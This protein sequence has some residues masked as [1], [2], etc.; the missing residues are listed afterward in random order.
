MKRI[1]KHC[2]T[3]FEAKTKFIVVCPACH[4]KIKRSPTIGERSCKECGRKF[5]GGPRAW[6][7]PE[8]RLDRRRERERNHRKNG[9]A[10][11]IGSTDLCERCGAAYTVNSGLQ[12]YCP[13]CAQVAVYESI[14]EE[15]LEYQAEYRAK[16]PGG[17]KTETVC[18]ICGKPFLATKPALTCSPECAKEAHRRAQNRADIKRGKRKSPPEARIYKK[19]TED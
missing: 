15:K 19:K 7:C 12:K 14:R 18:I 5:Q 2:G 8:C 4:D 17:R 16:N 9:T 11:K 6:Y 10:R 1:C 3:E 13:D